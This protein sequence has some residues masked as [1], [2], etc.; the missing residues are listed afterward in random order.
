M[1]AVL[2]ISN[3]Q[4]QLISRGSF[5][6]GQS[7]SKSGCDN[8][9]TNLYCIEGKCKCPDYLTMGFANLPSGLSTIWNSD[10]KKCIALNGAMCHTNAETE[11]RG[12]IRC[13]SGVKCN[14]DPSAKGGPLN[15]IG[16]CGGST[17]KLSVIAVLAFC[18]C[19]LL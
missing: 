17:T 15:T 2:L 16:T 5:C 19:K 4:P 13:Q 6:T 9:L 14:V 3:V 8:E 1:F 11:R 18:S 12:T 10:L 7:G